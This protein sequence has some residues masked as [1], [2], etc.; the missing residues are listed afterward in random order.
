MYQ[1]I[2]ENAGTAMAVIEDNMSVSLINDQFSRLSGFSRKDVEGK[3][4]WP[5]FFVEDDFY[6]IKKYHQPKSSASNAPPWQYE[7]RFVAKDKNLKDVSVTIT[8]I[9]GTD[10]S[11]V[12]LADITERKPAKNL[13]HTLANSLQIGVY[14][15]QNRTIVFANPHIPRYS[16]YSIEELLGSYIL[17]YVHP[18]DR[19]MVKENAIRM[20]KKKQSAPYEYRII[21]KNGQ[22]RWLM[23]SVVPI[24]YK[25]KRAILGNTMDIT[26]NKETRKELEK[27]KI[28]ESSILTSVPHALFGLEN[29]RIIF[30]NA[31][32]E[33]VFGWKPYE[34]IGKTTRILFRSDEEFEEIGKAVYAELENKTIDIREPRF[35]YIRKDGKE[36]FCRAIS[37]R[38]GDILAQKRVVTTFEDI[39]ERK[40]ADEALRTSE[41][42]YRAVIDNI[43]IGVSLISPDMEILDLNTQ[44]RKWV[45][46]VDVSTR[47]ICYRTFNDPP[48]DTICSYCPTYLTLQDGEIHESV[49]ETPLGGQ[50]RNYRIISSPIKDKAGNVTGAIEMV[51]DITEHLEIQERLSKSEKLY[52]TLFETTGTATVIVDEDMTILMINE[53]FETITGYT[54]QEIEGK[55]KWTAFVEKYDLARMKEY[56][57]LRRIDPTIPPRTYE[58]RFTDRYG[59][60]KEILSTVAIIPETKR[61][62]A[63]FL[64]ITNLKRLDEEIRESEAKYRLL[65][66]NISDIIWTMDTNL[67]ATYVSPSVE[68]LRGY[69]ADEAMKQTLRDILTPASYKTAMKAFSQGMAR[70]QA[71]PGDLEGLTT[72]ELE[73]IRK[74]GSTIWTEVNM[75]FLRDS[76]GRLTEILGITRDITRRKQAEE[77]LKL[78]S[79]H[80]E[81]TNTAL[82][83]LLEHREM[84]KKELQG[85]IFSNVR[86]LI[87]P[88]IEKV[89]TCGHKSEQAQ[90]L[91][92]LEA[93]LNNIISPFLRN[94]TLDQYKLTPKEIQI[95]NLI[96]EGKTTKEMADLLHISVSAI[97]YHRDNIRKKLGL[98]HRK[99]NLQS[100][101]S[102]LA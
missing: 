14:I 39:T 59:N 101:L 60:K 19:E 42:R 92:I 20:I 98:T 99:A 36:I 74:D 50:I 91:D 73:M 49:T 8:T 44:M 70:E 2:F 76:E 68:K 47:P 28:L 51:E 62:I 88:Y 75:T 23:E 34:V 6:K 79:R 87:I 102:S 78:K 43:A 55:K 97:N 95:A 53:E 24:Y 38:I 82:K 5:E 80:L 31:A 22:V 66:E 32:V 26:E 54:K 56:H 100:H 52:R 11:I 40:Q 21:D 65:A 25:G 63:S 58:F 16:G 10:K 9:S 35:P 30:V 85:C 15:V 84:D 72:L 71:K 17:N 83:V 3:K 48:R 7:A 94:L 12:S 96:K 81:E 61:S 41:A 4:S 33:R 67:K 37:S 93:N 45:P 46:R 1:A 29:R 77:E 89:K 64:D 90:Y 57:K 27:Q 69:R 13:Y 86:E 18:E